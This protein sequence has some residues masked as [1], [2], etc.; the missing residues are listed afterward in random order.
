MRVLG[1]MGSPR[2]KG[3]TALLLDEAL[4][5]ARSQDAEVKKIIVCKLKIE[6]C[7]ECYACRKSGIC[8]IRDDMD[9]VYSQLLE[10]DA[11]II[12]SPIFFCG[13]PAQLKAIIDRCQALWVRKYELN[14]DPGAR[15]GA[16]IG[17]G[18]TKGPKLFEGSILTIKYFF[19]TTGATYSEELLVRGVDKIGE[20]CQQPQALADAFELG[21]RIARE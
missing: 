15:R 4:K 8:S 5:G 12:A 10:S 3:N 14:Q 6:P 21:K 13:L 7:Q 2:L 18:A 17:V 19:K 16:F 1:I 11:I 20:I 9:S